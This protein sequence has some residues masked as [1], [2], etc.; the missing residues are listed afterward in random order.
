MSANPHDCYTPED[1]AKIYEVFD[2]DNELTIHV[3]GTTSVY[4]K[5]KSFTHL[6]F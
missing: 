4:D 6:S 3:V 5:I 2:K 1:W